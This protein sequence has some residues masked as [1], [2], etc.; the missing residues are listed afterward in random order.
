MQALIA[1]EDNLYECEI[2]HLERQDESVLTLTLRREGITRL[3]PTAH[4]GDSTLRLLARPQSQAERSVPAEKPSPRLRS[5]L[6]RALEFIHNHLDTSMSLQEVADAAGLS[7]HHFAHLFKASMGE[8]PHRYVIRQR[9]ERAR[10]LLQQG[11][12]SLAEVALAVGFYDQAHF[13]N[14][15]KRLTG[16][17]PKAALLGNGASASIAERAM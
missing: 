14:N 4:T 2:L 9:V 16:M 7:V 13:T 15:F 6:L 8:T 3:F 1:S 11:D 17:T 12:L 10:R 5:E